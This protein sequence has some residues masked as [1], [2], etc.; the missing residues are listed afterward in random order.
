MAIAFSPPKMFLLIISTLN[1]FRHHFPIHIFRRTRAKHS[2][3]TKINYFSK[4]DIQVDGTSGTS[5]VSVTVVGKCQVGGTFTEIVPLG[6]KTQATLAAG[7]QGLCALVATTST[8]YFAPATTTIQAYTPLDPVEKAR[9][10]KS[11]V[12]S[13]RIFD[14]TKPYF[15]NK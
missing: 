10:A 1:R 9:I 3:P 15:K 11:F 6:V 12:L 4:Y 8:P 5:S 2:I 14:L 7:Y 13:G